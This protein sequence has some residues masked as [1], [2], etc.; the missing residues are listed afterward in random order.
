VDD[1]FLAGA[2][3]GGGL[4]DEDW[5]FAGDPVDGPEDASRGS[6][7]MEPVV[8]AVPGV[9]AGE[10][11]TVDPEPVATGRSDPP[12]DAPDGGVETCATAAPLSAHIRIAAARGILIVV[13]P[14]VAAL[15]RLRKLWA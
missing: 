12:P 1:Y 15:R 2:F 8:A 14:R 7:V 5:V 9:I 11:E 13:S 10:P 6:G 3:G 4:P